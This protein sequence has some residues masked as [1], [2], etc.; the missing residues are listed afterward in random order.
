[1]VGVVCVVCTFVSWYDGVFVLGVVA[2]ALLKS[3]F[4]V[5]EVI[6]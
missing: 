6:G 1:V 2:L 5:L 3:C 4:Y